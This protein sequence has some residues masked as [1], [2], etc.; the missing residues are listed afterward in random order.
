VVQCTDGEGRDHPQPV[1]PSVRGA[2][3]RKS[4][5]QCEG[6]RGKGTLHVPSD[7]VVCDGPEQRAIGDDGQVQRQTW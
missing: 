2:P 5:G 4:T 6:F 3:E 7:H 1:A